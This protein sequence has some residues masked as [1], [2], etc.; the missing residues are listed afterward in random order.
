MKKII[1]KIQQSNAF[2]VFLVKAFLFYITWWS[3][4]NLVISPSHTIDNKV[5]SNQVKTSGFLLNALGFDVKYRSHNDDGSPDVL[6]I[7]GSAHSLQVEQ[8]CDSLDL[9][10]LFAVFVLAYPGPWKQRLWYIPVGV[11]LIHL[12][13]IVRITSLC[14]I[15]Y[16]D[17]SLLDFN[18]KYTFT[19]VMY[20]FIFGLWYY[21]VKKLSNRP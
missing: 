2:T 9:M 13:N 16:K 19:G 14:I 10:G 7:P 20:L 3:L 21:W 6:W 5:I 1:S 4:Y 12:L 17:P 15:E 18:H 8:A 11:V